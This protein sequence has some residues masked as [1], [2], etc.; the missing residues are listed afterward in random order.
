MPAQSQQSAP[1]DLEYLLAPLALGF[2]FQEYWNRRALYLPGEPGKFEGLFGRA[3]FDTA[4]H[5]CSQLKINYTDERGWPAERKITPAEIPDL[6][7][8]GKTIC[9]G[10]VNRGDSVLTNFLAGF[11]KQFLLAGG[12]YFN[13]YLSP[14]G[15]GFGLH[16]DNHPVWILQIEGQKRWRFSETPG[17]PQVVTNVSFPRDRDALKLPW[18]TV[19]RPAPESLREET[20]SPGDLLYLPKGSWHQAEAVG[21]SLGLTLAQT[22]V[23]GID[24]LQYALGPLLGGLPYRDLLPGFWSGSPQTENESELEPRFAELLEA[25]RSAVAG[26][27]PQQMVGLWQQAQRQVAATQDADSTKSE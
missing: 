16:L 26:I 22:G 12:F 27:T 6:L 4:V 7:A 11:K 5:R 20:L 2:F 21:G 19:A 25:I 14:D 23:A 15:A 3:A 8:S 13:A 24:I 17:L 9:A 1:E 18:A 10:N